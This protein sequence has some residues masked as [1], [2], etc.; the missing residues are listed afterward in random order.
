MLLGNF[1]VSGGS[2]CYKVQPTL[3]GNTDMSTGHIMS[4]TSQW[5]SCSIPGEGK[6][7]GVNTIRLGV[8]DDFKHIVT[9]L[10]TN[11]KTDLFARYRLVSAAVKIH[12]TSKSDQES[13]VVYTQYTPQGIPIATGV[14]MDQNMGRPDKDKTKIYLAGL[15]DGCCDG[16]NGFVEMFSYY[17]TK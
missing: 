2:Y 11:F 8:V 13:G 1:G 6:K 15:N 9:P 12:K 16:K 3:V 17:P 4:Q 7:V 14:P 10:R 5:K